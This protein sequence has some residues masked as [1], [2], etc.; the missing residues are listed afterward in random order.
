MPAKSGEDLPLDQ[1][2]FKK[3]AP[4]MDTNDNQTA[5]KLEDALLDDGDL[6]FAEL[7]KTLESEG[8]DVG[9]FLSKADSAYAAGCRAQFK[10][11]ANAAKLRAELAQGSMFGVL[12]FKSRSELLDLFLAAVKGK[13]GGE[14]MARCRNK[15]ADMMSESELRSWLED[16]EKISASK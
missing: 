9:K 10:A 5:R 4:T 7:R 6:S 3:I 1:K 12:E 11:Q 15:T 8:V 16:I 13:F 14:A 2:C